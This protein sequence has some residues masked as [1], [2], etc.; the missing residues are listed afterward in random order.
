MMICV[1]GRLPWLQWDAFYV[2]NSYTKIYSFVKCKSTN[3]YPVLYIHV[4]YF[5]TSPWHN[6]CHIYFNVFILSVSTTF[7][8]WF[9][10]MSWSLTYDREVALVNCHV[11]LLNTSPETCCRKAVCNYKQQLGCV[12]CTISW[13]M[14]PFLVVTILM[15]ACTNTTCIFVLFCYWKFHLLIINNNKKKEIEE[16]PKCSIF[17]T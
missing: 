15:C 16:I 10:I 8:L 2:Y 14:L 3:L 5:S 12:D 1:L 17:S 11:S 4:V 7:F 9:W 6:L 13:L